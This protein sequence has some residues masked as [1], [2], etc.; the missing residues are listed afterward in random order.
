MKQL[1]LLFPELFLSAAAL[2]ALLGEAFGWENKKNWFRFA[3]VAVLIALL[4]QIGFFVSGNSLG[5]ASVGLSPASVNGGWV[6]YAPVFGMLS[7]DSLSVFFNV[8]ILIAVLMILWLSVDYHEFDVT[9]AGTYVSLLLLA[10]VGM[11]MLAGSVDFLMAV[12]ALELLSIPSFILVGFILSRKTSI[13]G[14]IKYFLVGTLSTAILLFGISYYYG[15]FGSTNLAPIL[16]Y[17]LTG[18]TPDFG[19]SLTLVLI[20]SGLGFKLAMVPFHMWA[21][22]AYEGAPTPITAFLS[23]APKAAAIGFLVRLFGNASALEMTPLLAILAAL[24]MTVGNLGALFQTNVKRLLAYSSVA[25]VGYILVAMTVGGVRGSQA[26][27]LYTLVYVF[28]NLGVFAGFSILAN[29]AKNDDIGVFAGL[30]GRSMKLALALVVLLLSM[31]GLPPTAGF[32]AKFMVFA[33]VIPNPALVWLAV[34]AVINSV[35]SLYYYF[36]IVHQMFFRD[37][38]TPAAPVFTPAVVC[39]L[40]L[41][42]GVTIVFGL[43]PMHLLDWVRGVMGS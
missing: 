24:T 22:D 27:M 32:I 31:S 18:Q 37:A 9:P 42:L 2:I 3:I 12:I 28:M 15:Y 19:L 5:A 43:V 21:P 34:V 13:E 11:L 40:V 10:T 30:S 29:Q 4:H 39:C 8:T 23:V 14:A 38:A 35:I 25:Q 41:A 17:P 33:S 1:T 7:V 36:R 6:Q 16:H 26:A 20:I